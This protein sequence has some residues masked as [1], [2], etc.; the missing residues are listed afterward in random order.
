MNFNRDSKSVKVV[1]IIAI[2]FFI[3]LLIHIFSKSNEPTIPLPTVVVQKPKLKEMVE[4]VTQTGTMV[5]YNS[6]NLVAR[7]EGYLDSIEFVDGTFIKKGKE[8]FVI[9]PEPYFEQLRAAKATVAAQKAALAYN[10]SEYARQQRMYKQHATSLN[11]VEKWYAKTLELTAEVD[12][13]E[14]DEVNAAIT[15]G[16]THIFAP[17]DGRIGRH[18]VDV[19][20]LVG[21]GEATN[22]ATIEQIDPIYVYFNLNELDL[23]KLRA[24]ARAQGFKPKDI[25]KVPV[26]ISLQNETTFKYKATLDFVNTGLNASTGTM[27]LRALLQNKDYVFVP[28]LF[29]KVRVAISRPQKQ[30]TVPDTAV[31]YD[32]IGPYILTVDNNN[33]V[34][35]KHVTL[36][37]QEEGV[38]AVIK[39]LDAQ[40]N[41]IVDGLQNA[42]PGNKVQV[43]QPASTSVASEAKQ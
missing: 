24:A 3:Y 13:A 42:T 38:R 10:K 18:L 39:G 14:A 25:S 6:V 12:K 41:V 40:E 35:L 30:L 4:Y 27:E 34:V 16:Y 17:F 19:G 21:H 11:E 1:A 43:Q 15:Y 5:A 28:G 29:V 31:L 37:S 20:N 7:V 33:A 36:G 23:I 8:L 26:E 22:L 2:L 32:Q 9:Q